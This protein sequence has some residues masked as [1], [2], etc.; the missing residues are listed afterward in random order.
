MFSRHFGLG[1]GYDHFHAS[2]DVEKARF[3]GNVTLGYSGL[4]A[5][6]VGSY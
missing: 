5:M 3:N 6:I 1:L 4:Q 2:L